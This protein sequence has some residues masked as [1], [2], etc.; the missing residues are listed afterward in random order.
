M[1]TARSDQAKN[2]H[3]SLSP[4]LAAWIDQIQSRIGVE[5]LRSDV[6]VLPAPRNRMR[7]PDAMAEAD[8]LIVDELRAAGWAAEWRP[9][10]F[11]GVSGVLGY[12]NEGR[13]QA[14]PTIYRHL[15]GANIVAC[16]PGER[17]TAA[18]VVLAHHDTITHS[19]GANDNGASV[20]AL[21][22]LARVLAPCRFEHSVILA[23]TD[24]EEI[25]F[26][27]ARALVSELRH[28]R[29]VLAAI[30]FETMA[31][32]ASAP[33]TQRLPSGIGLLYP[34]QAAWI[35]AR[36]MRG[37]FTAVIYNWNALPLAST[38]AAGLSR[39]AGPDSPLLLRAPND[40]PIVGP[41][42]HRWVPAVRNFARSDHLPFWEA[43]LPALLITDTANFRYRHYHRPTDT[44]EKLDYE[45]LAA[46]VGA[47]AGAIAQVA[48]LIHD[49]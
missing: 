48:E 27:G 10:A 44:P 18:I 47:T 3:A 4:A 14:P 17:S 35:S 49:P 7:A 5:R 19:P 31:Y 2:R 28:E 40:L 16:K 15:E 32:T 22:E 21:L 46:I 29:R 1:Y 42:L 33:N 37:D 23:A 38:F 43:G 26:F 6:A 8:R 36:Q 12:H 41:L 45:R 30:N 20:A 39:L 9:F 13:S 24:M 34:R 11:S 25:G